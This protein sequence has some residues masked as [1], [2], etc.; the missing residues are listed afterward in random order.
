MTYYSRWPSALQYLTCWCQPGPSSL[1]AGGSSSTASLDSMGPSR[2]ACPEP[3]LAY[4]ATTTAEEKCLG[5]WK[6]K[7]GC[8]LFQLV[9][10]A[11][12]AQSYSRTLSNLGRPAEPTSS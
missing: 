4:C 2:L 7:A 11:L 6:H 10:Q 3:F 9:G 1:Q 8:A 12:Y 5:F